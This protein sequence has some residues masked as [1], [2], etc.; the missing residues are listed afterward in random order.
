M[1]RTDAN[2]SEDT[3]LRRTAL[4]Y[5]TERG[6]LA[7]VSLLLAARASPHAKDTGGHTCVHYC[8]VGYGDSDSAKVAILD[9]LDSFLDGHIAPETEVLCRSETER[10][11][12]ILQ[13]QGVAYETS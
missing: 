11:R 5:A 1:Y 6:C 10:V 9:V 12:H 2:L 7:S 8:A 4:M 3:A 13:R